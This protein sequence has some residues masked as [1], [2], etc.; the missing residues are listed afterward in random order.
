[1]DLLIGLDVD[2]SEATPALMRRNLRHKHALLQGWLSFYILLHS[3][4]SRDF[5]RKTGSRIIWLDEPARPPTASQH[6]A[7]K[8]TGFSMDGSGV[9]GGGDSALGGKVG[10][11]QGALNSVPLRNR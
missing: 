3:G 8:L 6:P 2:G 10:A 5:W 1:M 11:C 4:P 7:I 9:L